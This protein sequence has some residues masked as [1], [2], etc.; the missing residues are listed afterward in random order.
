MDETIQRLQQFGIRSVSFQV[1]AGQPAT[2]DYF[3]VMNGNMER[4][5][6]ITTEP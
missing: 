3:S 6:R 5:N 2:G 1:A 4:L